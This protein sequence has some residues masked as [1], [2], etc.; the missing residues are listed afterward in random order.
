MVA[1]VTV[2]LFALSL[3]PNQFNLFGFNTKKIAPLAD[4]L[5]KGVVKKVP[6][7]GVVL[8]DSIIATDSIAFAK[9]QVDSTNIVDFDHDSTTALANFFKSLNQ[10]KRGKHKTRIAYFGDSM[11][12]G[13]LITQD[14]RSCLQDEFGGCGVGYMPV[15]SLVAGFRTSVIHSF[16]G[17]TSYNLL[18]NPP[19]GHQLGISGFVFVPATTAASDSTNENSGSWV[20]YTGVKQKHLDKFSQM[21]LLYGKSAVGNFVL[22]NGKK[23][24]L[25]GTNAVNQ[26][27]YDGTLSS[28]KAVFKC[29][30]PMDVYGFSLEADTGIV[31]DNFSFRGN[32][33]MPIAK[34]SQAVYSG[35]NTYFNYDLI[36]LEYGLNAVDPKVT[37]FSW[38]TRGM[39]YVIKHI[40]ASFPNTS[41]LLISVGDKAFRKDGEYQTDPSVP[42]LV[43]AQREMAE[44]NNVAFW[45]LFDAMGGAGSMVKWV[46]GDTVY[47]NKDYTHFNF[48]GA[49]KVGKMLYQKVMSE[50]NDYNKKQ[51]R[52]SLN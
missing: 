48:K 42:L 7:P 4:I 8:T 5:A 35:T 39:N 17:W 1:T 20:K 19:A 18:E 43:K 24:A 3:F 50:Y 27:E 2:V 44:E 23:Y 38:Y 25:N 9:R 15:T 26:I 37:D 52:L 28:V 30:H 6:L 21:R 22:I 29:A 34:I 36:I 49:H 45:S 12:E 31:V 32:S 10:T 33:G 40:Q 13:D 47:A 16:E 14:F 11:I 51:N 41:I 46:E